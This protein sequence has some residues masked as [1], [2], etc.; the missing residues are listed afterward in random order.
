MARIKHYNHKTNKWEYADSNFNIGSNID[1]YEQPDVPEDAPVGSLWYDTD[2][3]PPDESGGISITG[4]KVGQTV[5]I[6]EV[7]ENGV[8]TAWESADFP[9]SGYPLA[10]NY[11][12]VETIVCDGTYGNISRTKLSLKKAKIVINMKAASAATTVC[13][14]AYNDAGL[15]GYSWLGNCI[16]TGERF[17]TAWFVSDGMNAYTEFTSPGSA[18][19]NTGGVNRTIY[20]LN[21]NTPINRLGIYTSPNSN[22]F[23]AESTIEIWGVRA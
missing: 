8:P 16:N 3:M 21:A 15:F 22:V 1:Y 20:P 14:E 7:D 5:K 19:Y 18:K 9:A 10:G 13:I 6:A 12:L 11:E 17:A 4:A 2:E 23:P